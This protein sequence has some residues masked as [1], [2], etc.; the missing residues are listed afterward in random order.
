[1]I[2]TYNYGRFVEEAI[3]SV[4][5]QDF[6]AE[7][8]EILVVDDGS[9]DDTAERVKKYG[10]RVC[11][12]YKP[13][14]G[15]ASA[16]NFGFAK[17]RGEIVA[18]LDA[19]DYW[20]PGKLRRVAEEFEKNPG[21]G[22]VY[23]QYAE[24][25]DATKGMKEENFRAVSGSFGEGDELFWYEPHPTSCT[26]YRRKYL[27]LLPPVPEELRILADVWIGLLIPFVAPI[28]AVPECLTAYRIHGKNLYYS[29]ASQL[30]AESRRTRIA[31]VRVVVEK[32]TPW[33]EEHGFR[34]RADV[35]AFV[36]RLR[37][38]EEQERFML[39]PPGRVRYFRHLM[40]YDACYG[41]HMLWRLRVINFVAALATLAAGFEQ[42]KRAREWTE[43]A[44]RKISHSLKRPSGSNP[45]R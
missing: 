32:M 8:M 2:D 5:A 36:D 40:F 35:Q 21:L 19:D 13:N 24:L 10:E 31:A 29:E 41:K 17:A 27:E 22:M 11:Y 4:L 20:L 1:M 25:D 33:I 7:E 18:L 37:L 43:G 9:T 14:G 39:E 38:Y 45:S 42:R 30:P 34:G 15:Q 26:A 16:F 3:E 28:L 44:A 23:H 6:P 12:F